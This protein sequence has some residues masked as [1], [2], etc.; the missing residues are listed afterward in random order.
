MSTEVEIRPF[1]YQTVAAGQ[2]A[3]KLIGSTAITGG[4]TG[5]LGDIL[6]T[7]LI[8]PATTSPGA[9]TLLD[10][11]TSITA[12]AG[13]ASSVPDL[14]PFLAV[15]GARSQNGAWSITTGSNVSVIAVGRFT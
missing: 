13:G 12:F 8:I 11:A 9:V 2:T 15:V 6:E 3:Q 14:K 1:R 5:A 10:G 7:V 4:G